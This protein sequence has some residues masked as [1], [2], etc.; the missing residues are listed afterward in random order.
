MY[1]PPPPP[2]SYAIAI[3]DLLGYKKH[4]GT[5]DRSASVRL[6]NLYERMFLWLTA[7]EHGRRFDH[8]SLTSAGEIVHVNEV[9]DFIVASDSIMLWVPL[10]KADFLA[11]A[12]A[13][14]F[15]RALGWGAALRGTIAA[16][17]CIMDL[18]RHILIGHPIVEAVEA[19]KRQNWLGVGVLPDP[20]GVLTS[21]PE[22]VAYA[23]PVHD[24]S[25]SPTLQHALAWHWYED[26]P[27]AAQIYLDRLRASAGESYR[28]K[29]EHA[30][31]FVR[32][33][34]RSNCKAG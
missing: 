1:P 31:S 5:V 14:L 23:V 2:K 10:Q 12:V 19:E 25:Q 7:V 4:L 21:L 28:L 13:R 3:L 20:D 30:D 22:V 24:S 16:G 9:V 8:L 6:A 11:A 15:I 32:S 33:M 17:E 18:E 34:Q 26:T 27:N 29:Y